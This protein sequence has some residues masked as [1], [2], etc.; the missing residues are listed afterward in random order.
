[1]KML[2]KGRIMKGVGSDLLRWR[3]SSPFF[4]SVRLKCAVHIYVYV[5]VLLIWQFGGQA[6]LHG[7]LWNFIIGG[8]SSNKPKLRIVACSMVR[9]RKS[10]V[11][12]SVV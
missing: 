8:D 11:I 10:L 1:M 4:F 3:I 12:L 6:C 5:A 2:Y 9:G 7:T